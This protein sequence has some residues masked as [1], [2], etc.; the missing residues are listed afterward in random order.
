MRRFGVDPNA[1]QIIFISHLHGD[2]FGGLPFFNLDTQLYSRRESP[3]LAG[4]PEFRMR[5]L[6]AME[7]FFPGSS[8]S[9]RKF[10]VDSPEIE[11]GGELAVNDVTH[12]TAEVK[13][14]CGA[15]RA[16]PSRTRATPSGPKP[17]LIG[18]AMR[19]SS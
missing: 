3:V 16:R 18:P 2:H 15:T 6:E 19:T 5:L 13:H 17:W 1:I 9:A 4:P 11:S 8:A 12:R 7:V 14:A 10:N